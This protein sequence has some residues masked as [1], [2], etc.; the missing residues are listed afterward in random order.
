VRS[1]KA[2]ASLVST[3]NQEMSCAASRRN[4]SL[5]F[6]TAHSAAT[7]LATAISIKPKAQKA[8][9]HAQRA[10]QLFGL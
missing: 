5:G 10:L 8:V 7:R 6:I 2:I 4:S 9:A 1:L 3:Q